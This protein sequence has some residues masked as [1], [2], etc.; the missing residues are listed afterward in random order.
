MKNLRSEG[1]EMVGN[2]C[3]VTFPHKKTFCDK[4]ESIGLT[5]FFNNF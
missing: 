1:V 3:C 4:I 2:Q 5:L